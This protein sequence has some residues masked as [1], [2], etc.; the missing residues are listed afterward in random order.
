MKPGNPVESSHQPL[1]YYID[2]KY[3]EHVS[4]QYRQHNR[5][6]Y[7]THRLVIKSHLGIR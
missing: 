3:I 4:T 1:T 6:Q 5:H 7:N 2:T